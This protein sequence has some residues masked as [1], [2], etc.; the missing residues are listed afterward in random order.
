MTKTRQKIG[1]LFHVSQRHCPARL[2]SCS[3]GRLSVVQFVKHDNNSSILSDIHKSSDL[4]AAFTHKIITGNNGLEK[5]HPLKWAEDMNSVISQTQELES[6]QREK[7][8]HLVN[9]MR[10]IKKIR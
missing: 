3:D 2:A 6:N 10:I 9:R 1:F 5:L 4:R 8:I 7:K